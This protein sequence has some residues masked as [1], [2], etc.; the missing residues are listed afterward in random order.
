MTSALRACCLLVTIV[1]TLGPGLWLGPRIAG[2]AIPAVVYQLPYRVVAPRVNADL[3]L[4][5][6]N[7]INQERV[8][9]GVRPLVPHATM[10]LVARRHGV[11]MFT[12][13]YLSHSSR[14]GRTPLDRVIEMNIRVHLVGENLAY[15]S[16]LLA[17][18]GAL[19]NSE[20]HR[21]NMLSPE[22]HLV[23]IGVLDGGAA[24]LIVV[25]TFGD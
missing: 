15:A 9:A 25:E 10:Q 4:V 12:F 16:D 6:L 11:D 14:D 17:A 24:G 13:G 8:A 5:A 23:G 18:H 19:V 21:R 22:Y 1:A 3:E 2:G 20:D 7:L